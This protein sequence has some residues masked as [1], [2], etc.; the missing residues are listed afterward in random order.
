MVIDD[1]L[2]HDACAGNVWM[3]LVLWADIMLGDE[4]MSLQ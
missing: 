3:C 4:L 1:I 2:K